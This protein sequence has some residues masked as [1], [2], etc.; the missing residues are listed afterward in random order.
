MKRTVSMIVCATAILLFCYSCKKNADS[1]E[2]PTT[3]PP[4]KTVLVT[5]QPEGEFT[6][7]QAHE[8]D[9]KSS[10][11]KVTAKSFR[12]TTYYCVAIYSGTRM[13]AFGVFKRFDSI[14]FRLNP[15]TAYTIR[16]TLIQRGTG[17]GLKV[18]DKFVNGPWG[19]HANDSM[20]YAANNSSLASTVVDYYYTANSSLLYTMYDSDSTTN[21]NFSIFPEA[22]TFF[23]SIKNYVVDPNHPVVN[24]TMRRL[25]FG[26]KYKCPQLTQG[27][28]V[29]NYTYIYPDA[30]WVGMTQKV[31][32]PN[33]IDNS[34]SIY[35]C[36]YLV[37]ADTVRYP[38]NNMKVNVVWELTDGRKFNV[39]QNGTTIPTPGR[40]QLLN[41]NVTL[42]NLDSG[43]TI[44][45][46]GSSIGLKLVDSALTTNTPIRF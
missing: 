26:I 5:L 35:S 46:T 19:G 15:D 39:V 44:P 20:S 40:N 10:N 36:G 4:A 22:T 34:L 42:P 24:I 9:A 33:T 38:Y 3:I 6:V 23:G 43:T 14:H 37:D 16:F 45:A 18:V 27:R 30:S 41:I 1:T 17:P 21:N 13:Y 12:D 25:V 2:P 7:E 11:G 29:V 31:Y 28:L 8:A 32:Y